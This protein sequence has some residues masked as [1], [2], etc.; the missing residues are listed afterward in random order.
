MTER[1]ELNPKIVYVGKALLFR[2]NGSAGI[3]PKDLNLTVANLRNSFE[4]EEVGQR[5]RFSQVALLKA[6]Y[7][8]PEDELVAEMLNPESVVNSGDLDVRTSGVVIGRNYFTVAAVYTHRLNACPSS[9]L[10]LIYDHS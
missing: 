4:V 9:M 6:F 5:C 2:L 10:Y 7:G 8:G 3:L 1:T